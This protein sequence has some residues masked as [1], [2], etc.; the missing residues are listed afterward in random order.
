MRGICS[1]HSIKPLPRTSVAPPK[2]TADAPM[3]PPITRR[4]IAGSSRTMTSGN[5]EPGPFRIGEELVEGRVAGSELP[6]GIVEL[7]LDPRQRRPVVGVTVVR[8]HG[9]RREERP[10][11]LPDGGR[12]HQLSGIGDRHCHQEDDQQPLAQPPAAGSGIGPDWAASER[13]SEVSRIMYVSLS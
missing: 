11:V 3:K 8:D 9:G 13:M 5:G 10:E 6:R 1:G 2:A 4:A 7:V 12:A